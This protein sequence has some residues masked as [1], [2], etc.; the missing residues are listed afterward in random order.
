MEGLNKHLDSQAKR[1]YNKDGMALKKHGMPPF[2]NKALQEFVEFSRTPA[3]I[4]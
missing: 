2:C 3:S 1:V 4:I